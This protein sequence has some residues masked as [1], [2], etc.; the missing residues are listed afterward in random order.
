MTKPLK[1]GFDL[2]GVLL[3]NPARIFRPIT[4]A[5]KKI[6]GGTEKK[7]L[8]FYYPHSPIEQL[9]W[10]MVHWSSMFIAPGFEDIKKLADEGRIEPYI[11][12]SR[13][14]C[15]TNDFD[16]WLKRMNAKKYF[17]GTYHNK[18]NVQPHVFKEQ[19]INKLNLE[20]FVEDNF[21]IVS[22]IT[23]T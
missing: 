4:L 12:T 13:Y 9:M 6:M 5:V 17:K 18:E 16:W 21:D 23:K 10:K 19:M 15:L 11:I 2:D 8:H 14:Q 7:E 3:Y 1:I 22:H 20:Y